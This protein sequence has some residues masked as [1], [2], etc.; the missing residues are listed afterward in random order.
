MFRWWNLIQQ[1]I[2]HLESLQNSFIDAKKKNLKLII[3]ST[4]LEY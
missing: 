1:T 3:I 2:F 4:A